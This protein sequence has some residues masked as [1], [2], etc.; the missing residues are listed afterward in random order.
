MSRMIGAVALALGLAVALGCGSK[1]APAPAPEPEAKKEPDAPPKAD[2]PTA[3]PPKVEPPPTEPPK[4][5]AA[6]VAWEMDADK[7]AVP[8][9]PVSGRIAGVEVKPDVLLNGEEVTFRVLKAGTPTV[10]RSV[11]L[12]LAPHD[13]TRAAPVVL[14]RNWKVKV[15]DAPGPNVPDIW[16]EIHGQPIVLHPGGYALTLELGARKDGKVAGKVY[17]SLPDKEQ[18]TLAGTFTTDYF[19][20]H[21]EKPGPDDVPYATGSVAVTGSDPKTEVRAA[22]AGFLP[23][24]TAA[25]KEL[26]IASDPNPVEQA[27]W[28]SDGD[29]T[30]P[31]TST[32]VPGDGKARP[33]RYEYTKLPPGRYLLSA[34]V[35][36]G[37]AVWKWVD[38]PAA[39]T[40]A[41]NLSLDATKA[42]GL[43]VAAPAGVTGKVFIAPADDP[44][45]APLEAELFKVLSIQV[46]RTDA[47]IVGGK[48]VVKNLG[49]G[50]YEVRLG[51]ERRF[52]DVVAGKIAEVNMTP[53]KK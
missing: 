49:P 27:L 16:V 36:G 20:P 2:P 7:H 6:K 24:G 46:V 31:R 8:A 34:A 51:D 52:V 9:A 12:K 19:R 22:Y 5:D 25:F 18:T 21:T 26:Q 43:E 50:K 41:E 45:R 11:S 23:N 37:P 33:F 28:T 4:T 32:L 35:A 1:P 10:E 15:G 38:V 53:A 17:L 42:G 47:E 30:K 44:G 40:L 3:A 39:G 48:A 13:P 29:G 14:G